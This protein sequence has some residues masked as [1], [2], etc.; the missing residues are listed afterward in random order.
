MN[1]P[2]ALGSL[3]RVAP[4]ASLAAVTILLLTAPMLFTSNGFANDWVNHLWLMSTESAQIH[5]TGLPS[6]FLN[7]E[8]LGVLYPNF[9]FYGGTF[10]AA[11]GY[12]MALTHSPV[13]VYVA[14]MVA[15]FCA[16][17]GG[18]LSLAWQAGVRG[19]RAHIPAIILISAA[20]YLSL[21]YGRA[22]TPELIGTSAI[23]A[24]FAAGIQIIRLGPSPVR[25][26]VLALSAIFWSGSHNI[27]FAWGA[28]F[29]A[30]VTMCMLLAWLPELTRPTLLRIGFAGVVVALGIMVNGWFLLP[31][32]RY[33]LFTSASQFQGI[34]TSISDVFNRPGIVFS[35]LRIR[36]SSNPLTRSHFT[37]LPVLVMGWIVVTT[38]LTAS[39]GLGSPRRRLGWLLALLT[40]G[41]LILLLDDSAWQLLPSSLT[42]IQFTFRLDTYIVMAVSGMVILLLSQLQEVGAKRAFAVPL[43]ASLWLVA[44]LGLGLGC[45]QVWNS[46]AYYVPSQ[47]NFLKSRANVLRYRYSVPPTWYALV[48]SATFRDRT[49]PVVPTQGAIHLN[50]A[51]VTGSSTSQVVSI[52]P[53]AG[54]VAS[55]IAAPTYVISV[56]G[57]K[58]VGRT[59]NG[60]LALARPADGAAR[61]RVSIG[62]SDSPA[63]RFAP[64][65]TVAGL[66]G[67]LACLIASARPFPRRKW[68]ASR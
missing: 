28:I 54:A 4:G 1:R 2:A 49:A 59:A 41:L 32:I 8:Q 57:M 64:Y 40:I 20:Y 47:Q 29:I 33:S 26:I 16:A 27:T 15:A 35:P 39:R 38:L 19:M 67:L 51:Q 18:T 31:D 60:F 5:R 17:Y 45:W 44:L 53:G 12:L 34:A 11:G 24:L 21:A 14:I 56:H 23:P 55:N 22:S 7:T 25:L 58:P 63:M 42:L 50:P 48:Y 62:R 68:T 9:L 43:T 65:L 61:V 6:L 13:T 36:A 66:L 3:R 10:Y 46:D 30:L 52:P 37:E